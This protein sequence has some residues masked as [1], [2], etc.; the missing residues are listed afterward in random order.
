M[1]YNH[2]VIGRTSLTAFIVELI[3]S[4]RPISHKILWAVLVFLFPI[5]GAIIYFLL[6]NRQEHKAGGYEPIP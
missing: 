5:V 1:R 4:N 6:S 2:A 3:Q